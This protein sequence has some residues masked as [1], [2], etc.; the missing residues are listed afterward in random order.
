M[1]I[2]TPRIGDTIVLRQRERESRRRGGTVTMT[3]SLSPQPTE[4]RNGG[5]DGEGGVI[6]ARVSGREALITR[7]RGM[8]RGL[9]RLDDRH[10]VEAA[11][12]TESTATPRRDAAG[13]L[14]LHS[15]KTRMTL[16]PAL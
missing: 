14:G 10:H 9:L 5:D 16:R 11:L 7:R 13:M 6:G 4:T 15:A 2:G 1:R 12:T 3:T 8:R